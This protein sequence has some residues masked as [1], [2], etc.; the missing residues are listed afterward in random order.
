MN[1]KQTARIVGRSFAAR[2]LLTGII[3]PMTNGGLLAQTPAPSAGTASSDE[4]VSLPAFEASAKNTRDEWFASQA[5]SGTRRTAPI[6]EL[7]YQ[8]QVVT[9]EFLED[10]QLISLSEQMSYFP[11]YSGRADQADAAIGTSVGGTALRGFN[12]TV[13]R[14]GF[15]SAP[16]PQIGNTAQVEVIKGPI[17][18]LYG[19]ANPGGLINY[20]SKRPTLRPT[21]KATISGGSYDYYRTNFS[22]SGP[23]FGKKLYYLVSADHYYRLGGVQY[24]YARQAD[25]L[26]TLLWKPSENTSIT[27]SYEYVHLVGA[28]AA[29]QPS[30]VVGTR[31]NG[32][33]PLA[34]T[35]GTVVGLDW[36]LAEMR[37]SRFGPRERYYRD[38]EGLNVLLQHSYSD[39]WKQRVAYFGQWKEFSLNFGTTSNVSA[40][41]NRMNNIFPRKR[42]QDI[43]TPAAVQTD[44]LGLFNTGKVEHQLLFTADY[45]KNETIDDHYRMSAAQ[46]ALLPDSLRYHDPFNPDWTT[47]VDYSLLTRR[48]D[49]I[50]ENVESIAGSVSD[51]VM[52][53]DRKL[54]LMGNLRYEYSEFGADTNATIDRLTVGD[55]ASWTHSVGAN[56]KIA[57]DRLVA[58]ANQSTSFSTNITI[59]RNTGTTIPNEKGQ[60]WEA[61]VKALTSDGRF[62]GSISVYEIIKKNIGQT[63]PEFVLGN[64]EPE[65]LGSG[66]E[67]ARGIEADVTLKVS[68]QLSVLANASYVD[69]LVLRSSNASLVGARKTLVPRTTGVLAARYRFVGQL[70]GL[71]AGASLIYAGGYV[72]GHASATR[73]YEEGDAK[74]VYSAYLAYEWTRGRFRNTVRLNGTNITDLLYVGPDNNVAMGRQINLTFTIALR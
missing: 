64:G 29:S 40:E 60:G 35:G 43:D 32:A 27:A 12:A 34:W 46:E 41:T 19:D 10:F 16:P 8:V 15:R 47:P 1:K 13:V 44:L 33:N 7:P 31:Q 62:G 38:Y 30:L 36:R 74:K 18:T 11:G 14:D 69:A 24:A 71:S 66:R 54:I 3:I 6:M 70:K 52:L 63:N 48:T 59:D 50:R 5:M 72:R 21:Y 39:N 37:Y 56:Y 23:V 67:R 4:V 2:L 25:Y 65:F 22:A 17:S 42:V 49:K 58:F 57:G 61:G 28:R 26:A 55:A 45:A 53:A 51:R 9:N 73:L 20:V 68:N